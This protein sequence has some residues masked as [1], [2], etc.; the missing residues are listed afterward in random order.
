M[1]TFI[2]MFSAEVPA[3]FGSVTLKLSHFQKLKTSKCASTW[4]FK[5]ILKAVLIG[6]WV[7]CFLI[8]LGLLKIGVN[9]AHIKYN[10]LIHW[11]LSNPTLTQ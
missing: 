10:M 11:L 6:W 1:Y 9:S 3:N 7:V 5:I 8:S 2:I 4:N